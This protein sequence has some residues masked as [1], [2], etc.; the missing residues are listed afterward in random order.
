MKRF[1][2]L[3]LILIPLAT[4]GQTVEG[5]KVFDNTYIGIS[6]GIRGW[7]YPTKAPSF[8]HPYQDLFDD[9][10]ESITNVTSLRIGKNITPIFG[11]EI[12]TEL[13][14]ASKSDDIIADHITLGG[15]ITFNLNNTFHKYKGYPD[16]FEVVPFVGIG[17]YR[18]L[19]SK[20]SNNLDL[21]VGSYLN[22]NCGKKRALQVNIVPHF[23]FIPTDRGNIAST[24]P[25]MKH[26]SYF[27]V[28]VG[29][30]YKFRNKHKTH[31]FVLAPTINDINNLQDCIKGKSDTISMKTDSLNMVGKELSEAQHEIAALNSKNLELQQR[32]KDNN[33]LFNKELNKKP[34]CVTPSIGFKRNKSEI[35]PESRGTI[36]SMASAIIEHNK[37]VVIKGYADANTGSRKF[38]LKLSE[39]RAEAVRDALIKE[40]VNPDNI[41]T[42]GVGD[43]EQPYQE[44]DANRTVIINI[45]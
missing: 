29:L 15:D 30:T 28:Q 2:L 24:L 4:I 32:I 43:V 8:T 18:T 33:D 7:F 11:L 21:R 3:I 20:H 26:K 22:I 19:S 9:C 42:I 41:T 6:S 14:L 36:L 37:K 23:G 35:T 5:T 34:I 44:N 1:Y 45:F 38:N 25:S 16:R 13:G 17:W 27:A 31:N 39:C 12:F 40:G 10:G